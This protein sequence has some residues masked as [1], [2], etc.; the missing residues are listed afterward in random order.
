MDDLTAS[1]IE[2]PAQL[3]NQSLQGLIDSANKLSGP[4]NDPKLAALIRHMQEQLADGYQ[5][6]VFC[7]YIATA[8]YVGEHVRKAFPD[9]CIQIVT[10]EQPPEERR[11]LV[12]SMAEHDRRLLV[13]TDRSDDRR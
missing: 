6:V 8:Q 4:Q 2:P 13:A 1:D 5:P 10:G 3:D 12:E 9:V 7:R 11:L